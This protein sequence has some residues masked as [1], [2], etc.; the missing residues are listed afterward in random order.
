MVSRP[1]ARRG[2]AESVDRHVLT[3]MVIQSLHDHLGMGATQAQNVLIMRVWQL[4]RL[5]AYA[6]S[7][8]T[9]FSLPDRG[10]ELLS[11]LSYPRRKQQA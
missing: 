11:S 2:G 4:N 6:A 5:T 3:E 1:V 8:L 10:G 9:A 7:L